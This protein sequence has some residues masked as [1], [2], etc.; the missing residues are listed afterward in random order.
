MLHLLA[1]A[2]PSPRRVGGLPSVY[3]PASARTATARRATGDASSRLV[4]AY[5]LHANA[6]KTLARG[7]QG[8]LLAEE[9]IA[10]VAYGM[11]P[12]ISAGYALPRKD[13][14]AARGLRLYETFVTG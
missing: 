13:Q 9:G 2:S 4:E 10:P 14:K 7:G 12:E 11:M 6:I 8:Y 5:R 3:C 1:R